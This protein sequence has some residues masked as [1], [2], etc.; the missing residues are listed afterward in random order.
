[1][2]MEIVEGTLHSTRSI[3]WCVGDPCRSCGRVAPPTPAGTSWHES[4]VVRYTFMFDSDRRLCETQY[5]RLEDIHPELDAQ[6][7]GGSTALVSL[8]R[9]MQD[10][11]WRYSCI[12]WC[13]D[14]VIEVC[15]AD[16]SVSD[17]CRP[18]QVINEREDSGC[19]GSPASVADV[20]G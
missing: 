1:M 15:N 18:E 9:A 10:G 3:E 7:I 6:G 4:P 2:N 5:H 14:P 13:F 19:L 8:H 12:A 11:S 20:A 16:A 17:S